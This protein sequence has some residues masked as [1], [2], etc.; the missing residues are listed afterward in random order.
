MQ[1]PIP[2]V[3]R[4]AGYN[5]DHQPREKGKALREQNE[6]QA[7]ERVHAAQ[8]TVLSA[9]DIQSLNTAWASWRSTFASVAMRRCSAGSGSSS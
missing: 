4:P 7:D 2:L 1:L 3:L 9:F 6:F 5:G 8:Y